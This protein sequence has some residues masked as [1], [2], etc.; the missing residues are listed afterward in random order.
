MFLI[1]GINHLRCVG[2]WEGQAVDFN[3]E[4]AGGYSSPQT[5][6]ERT[7][8]VAKALE[9]Y[10]ICSPNVRTGDFGIQPITKQTAEEIG[11][12]L[13]AETLA[14]YEGIDFLAYLQK[15]QTCPF[16]GRLFFPDSPNQKI[17]KD[18]E[19]QRKRKAKKALKYYHNNKNK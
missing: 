16:C 2:L 18:P 12:I 5:K 7:A 10:N 9:Y 6:E 15:F 1:L 14:E 8:C 13:A 11:D 19:C 3:P 4:N 17:C